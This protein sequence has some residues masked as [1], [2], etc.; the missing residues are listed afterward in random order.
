MMTNGKFYLFGGKF[1]DERAF[2]T[3]FCL[4]LQTLTWQNLYESNQVNKIEHSLLP[5]G[6]YIVIFGGYEG[7]KI[8]N[9]II[10]YDIKHNKISEVKP[11][12]KTTKHRY[13]HSAIFHQGEMIIYGGR[14]AQNI[15]KD[16]WSFSF[17]NYEW[18]LI[19]YTGII[20]PLFRHSCIKMEEYFLIFGG[21]IDH[22]SYS[23]SL[24][25]V[26]LESHDITNIKKLEDKPIARC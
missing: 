13:G 25:L 14:D 3:F 23:S 1:H 16:M 2:S 22:Q 12:N 9:E 18:T 15:L 26:D 7:K 4:D 8:Y 17:L 24:Y 5:I 20:K 19:N 11:K 21:A 6:D 10:L